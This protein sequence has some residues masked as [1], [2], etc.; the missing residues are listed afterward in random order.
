MSEALVVPIGS[1]AERAFPSPCSVRGR[2]AVRTLRG[3]ASSANWTS[4]RRP[5]LNRSCSSLSSTPGLV[6]LD[7]RELAP[8]KRTLLDERHRR[9]LVRLRSWSRSSM[10]DDHSG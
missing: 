7:L 8:P 10:S 4:R 9:I 3:S 1:Q 2:P 5:G 6:V